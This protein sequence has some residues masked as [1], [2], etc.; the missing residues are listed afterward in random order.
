VKI[1]PFGGTRSSVE[2]S[3]EPHD[4]GVN[5]DESSTSTVNKHHSHPRDMTIGDR[6]E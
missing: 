2:G 6:H 3:L 4:D 1:G 5:L